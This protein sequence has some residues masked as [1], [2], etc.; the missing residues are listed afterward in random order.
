MMSEKEI[1]YPTVGSPLPRTIENKSTSSVFPAPYNSSLP[2]PPGEVEKRRQ[3]R[4]A[5]GLR[6]IITIHGLLN[7]AIIVRSRSKKKKKFHVDLLF[8]RFFSSV[9]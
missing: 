9:F 7:I 5:T 6:F 1:Q 8:F 4:C 2:L 3:T